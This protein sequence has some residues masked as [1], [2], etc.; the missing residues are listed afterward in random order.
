MLVE[1]KIAE[2]TERGFILKVGSDSVP[3][4]DE[5]ATHFWRNRAP[6]GR[7]SF[8]VGDAVGVRLKTDAT[9]VVLREMAD[10]DTWKWLD[11]IR[12]QVVMGTLLRAEAK[13]LTLRLE[14]GST[15]TFRHSDKSA[16]DLKGKPAGLNDLVEGQKLYVKGR[17]LP[18]LD[19]WVV[20]LSDVRPPVKESKATKSAKEKP[21]K[22]AAAGSIRGVVDHHLPSHTMFD[23]WYQGRLIHITYTARTSFTFGGERAGPIDLRKGIGVNVTYRRDQLGRLVATKIEMFEVA[24]NG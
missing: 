5:S 11:Q 3:V 23:I 9:P 18:S 16:I 15:F 22:I 13:T 8:S 14:D 6:S 1:A 10:L 24:N 20:S 4:Q 2:V 19:T 17:L 21:L 12:K 7:T